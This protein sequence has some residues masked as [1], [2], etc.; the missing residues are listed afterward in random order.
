MDRFTNN[1]FGHVGTI[2]NRLWFKEDLK[3][4]V[5]VHQEI[6][7]KILPNKSVE[8]ILACNTCFSS[9]S[10]NKIPSMSVYN[11]FKFPDILDHL[12]PLDIISE[13]LISPR[14]PFMQFRRLCYVNG[15]YGIYGQIINVPVSVGTMIKN[16]SRYIEDDY[17]IKL[18][19]KCR[20][21]H[22]TTIYTE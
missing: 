18:H 5:E 14:I 16:I 4:P 19:F 1:P 20:K 12:P 13:R 2:C 6:L 17:C 21:I 22:Q 7:H 15:Q 3:Q 11:G 8:D 10:K 9:L